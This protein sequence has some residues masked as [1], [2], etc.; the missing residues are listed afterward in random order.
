MPACNFGGNFEITAGGG[1]ANT[2]G[3][4]ATTDYVLQMKTLLRP[5]E[6]NNYGI[7]FAAGLV[8]H[9]D[10]N[11]GPNLLGNR[12]A[13]VPLSL[14]LDNDAVVL[15]ANLGW[16]RDRATRRD[17]LTWGIGGEFQLLPRLTA[18][19]EVFG[20]NRVQPYSQVGARFMLVP[21]IVQLDATTGQQFN[22]PRTSRWVSFGLRLT[23]DRLF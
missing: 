23:P 22:G 11:P 4:A 2:T 8:R 9:P 15:H 16:L 3:G 20:D 7:G 1:R 17:N 21:D 19:A 6:P 13:Y 5:L 14:S 12:Y 10:V 18:I